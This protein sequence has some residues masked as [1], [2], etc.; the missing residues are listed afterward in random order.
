MVLRVKHT[1]TPFPTNSLYI[2]MDNAP[3]HSIASVCHPWGECCRH[4]PKATHLGT[5]QLLLWPQPFY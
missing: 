4:A 1:P 5:N 2:P 3:L